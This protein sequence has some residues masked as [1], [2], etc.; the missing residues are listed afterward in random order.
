MATEYASMNSFSDVVGRTSQA[1][2][3]KTSPFLL[4]KVESSKATGNN[5]PLSQGAVEKGKSGITDALVQG[6]I[7]RLP[8]P[9]SVWS[10]DD[11][12]RWLR[13]A[14]SIFDLV[15]SAGDDKQ[16]EIKVAI[17]EQEPANRIREVK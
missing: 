6:L 10:L 4:R 13:T 16:R 17:V 15:Y 1:D 7:E 12:A 3:D 2:T 11:R 9:D 8:K 14:D 5:L